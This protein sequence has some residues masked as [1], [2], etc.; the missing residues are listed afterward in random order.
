MTF[1]PCF[2]IGR[3]IERRGIGIHSGEATVAR[4]FPGEEGFR[5]RKPGE[6][7]TQIVPGAVTSTERCTGIAGVRTVEHLLSALLGLGITDA[8]IEVDGLEVPILDGSS[9]EWVEAIRGVGAVPTGSVR[10]FEGLTAVEVVEEGRRV[11]VAP[12]SGSLFAV[13][14]RWPFPGRQEL[15][16]SYSE[17]VYAREIAPARTVALESEVEALLKAGHGRG[18]TAENTLVIG[19][20]GYLTPCRFEDEPVRHK[21][22][23]C[24]G[25]LALAGVP[26]RFLDV[27]CERA[28]HS[29]HVAAARALANHLRWMER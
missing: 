22:L 9:L 25:D 13:Y 24:I 26:L 3:A 6:D 18:G 10:V 11:R 16:L 23:D 12:G 5:I 29:L 8:D 21:L 15:T 2:T 20:D 14:E 1:F 28:G 7:W 27:E 19:S 4:V 17:E